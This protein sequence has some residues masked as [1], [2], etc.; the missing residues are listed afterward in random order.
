MAAS[1]STDDISIWLRDDAGG[2]R[3]PADL[4]T[5]LAERLLQAGLPL[6]AMTLEITTLHPLMAGA[7]FTWRRSGQA[8]LETP[9]FHDPFAP[10]PASAIEP[11]PFDRHGQDAAEGL[12][13]PIT[14]SDGGRHELTVAAARENS[15]TDVEADVIRA[16]ALGFGAPLEILLLK[17][18][19]RVLMTT[20]LGAR[21]ADQ[22]L[23]G[24]IRRGLCDSVDAVL[25]YSDL[26][27]FT[28]CSQNLSGDAVIT[29]LNSH[30]ERLAAP[31]KAFGGEV[32]KFMGDGLLAIFPIETAGS[33]GRACNQAIK[34]VRAA[35]AGMASL[36]GERQRRGERSLEFGV[37]LHVGEVMYGNIGAPD[38]LD[39]TVIGPAVNLA[40]RLEACCKALRCPVLI[41]DAFETLSDEKLLALGSRRLPDIADPI[42]IFT[43][44]EFDAPA[45]RRSA[46]KRQA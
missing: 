8:A 30:F 26:R 31:I 39:F 11:L 29:L 13:F 6:E 34:S 18:M 12:P 7:V 14:T 42:E 38:R 2:S 5:G 4:L 25:W 36:N 28:A 9:R 44:Q 32:L 46:A 20:Y 10:G 43:L 17:Q 23:S 3:S 45:S 27:G 15:F 19:A 37:A 16:A 40:S 22:V 41:S 21:T 1:I 33:A 24:A 35:R